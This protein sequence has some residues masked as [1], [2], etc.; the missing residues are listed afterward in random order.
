MK[1]SVTQEDIDKA[2][3][4]KADPTTNYMNEWDCPICQAVKRTIQR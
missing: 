2:K 3:A 1:I 4:L